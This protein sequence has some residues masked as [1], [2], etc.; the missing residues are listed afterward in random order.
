MKT[1][2]QRRRGRLWNTEG[3]VK[4]I[5]ESGKNIREKENVTMEALKEEGGGASISRN[6]IGYKWEIL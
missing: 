6:D 1:Y 2:N 3:A 4:L 5:E